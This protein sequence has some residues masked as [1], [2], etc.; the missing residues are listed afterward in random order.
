MN[1][2]T[3]DSLDDDKRLAID[4]RKKRMSIDVIEQYDRQPGRCIRI[5]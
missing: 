5:I 4:K 3:Y 2:R 1:D